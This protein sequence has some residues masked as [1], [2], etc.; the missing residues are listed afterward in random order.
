MGER[1]PHCSAS[2]ALGRLLKSEFGQSWDKPTSWAKL[3][4]VLKRRKGRIRSA[5][6]QCSNAGLRNRNEKTRTRPTLAAHRTWFP[7]MTPAGTPRAERRGAEPA[8]D[9][10]NNPERARSARL[11]S[12]RNREQDWPPRCKSRCNKLSAANP[13]ADAVHAA[14]LR[15]VLVWKMS[16]T[17]CF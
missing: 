7:V 12:G 2:H 9:L 3:N 11:R 5:V 1:E 13:C 15:A 16:P 8:A 4:T 14:L 6:V 10:A 17:L